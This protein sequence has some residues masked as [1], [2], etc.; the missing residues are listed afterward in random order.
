MGGHSVRN[1][2]ANFGE[3]SGMDLTRLSRFFNLYLFQCISNLLSGLVRLAKEYIFSVSGWLK[4]ESRIEITVVSYS[5]GI[6]KADS[7][8]AQ[9]AEI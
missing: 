4:E 1:F 2:S 6:L 3:K 7:P 5:L 9:V 8:R